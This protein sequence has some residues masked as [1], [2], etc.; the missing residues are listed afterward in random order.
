MT[1]IP[2]PEEVDDIKELKEHSELSGQAELKLKTEDVGG[3]NLKKG[4][5][6]VPLTPTEPALKEGVV[7]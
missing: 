2:N 3:S 5:G 6:N 1:K 4:K 7:A